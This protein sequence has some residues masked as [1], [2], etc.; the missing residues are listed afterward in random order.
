MKYILAYVAILSGLH[1]FAQSLSGTIRDAADGQLLQGASVHWLNTGIGTTSDA[2]GA[3][4]IAMPAHLPAQMVVSYIGYTSDTLTLNSNTTLVVKLRATV[5]LKETEV[6]ETREAT[7]FSTIDPLNKQSLGVKELQKSACCNLSESFETNATVDVSYTDAVSGSKQIKLLGLEGSYTQVL[8][9]LMPGIRGLST[10]SGYAH[11]P[12]T[13]VQNIDIT[14]GTGSVVNGYES[15]SGQINIDLLKPEKADRL[16]VNVYAG[17]A[18]RYE[19]NVHLGHRFNKQWSSILLTHASGMVNKNDYNGDGYLDAPLGSQFNVMNKWRYEKPG[20]LMAMFGVQALVDNRQGGQLLFRNQ[21]DNDSMRAYGIRMHTQH[22]EA[23]SKTAWGF[24]GQPYKGLALFATAR[25][26]AQD[27]TYGLKTYK[28]QEQTGTL[29]LMYQSIIG[30]SDHKI[31]IGSSYLIDRY[32]ESYRD[33]AFSRTESVPGIFGE[34]NYERPGKWS[35]LAGM[36]ADYHNLFGLMLNPRLHLKFN[37]RPLTVLR[38]SAGRGMHTA[39][40]FIENSAALASSRQV[41]VMEKL[42]QEVAWNYGTS[43]VHKFQLW[44]RNVTFTV[45]LYRTDFEHQVVAD[46]DANPQQLIFYN[47][48]GASYSNNFQSEVAYEPFKR[49]ELRLAYKWQ[50]VHTTYH[51]VLLE[52]PLVARNRVL[53]NLAYATRFNKWKFDFTAK[54]FDRS[55]LPNTS[56]NP[57]GLRFDSYSR[58]Y[59]VFNT[60]VTRAFKR[61]EIYA[62]VENIFN[63]VQ[64]NQLIDPGNPFGPYFD[65]SMVWGPVMGRVIYGGLRFT[66]K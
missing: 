53:L 11:L 59:T 18:G 40:V 43:L 55:R 64:Q 58:P 63:Y 22:I 38:F 9:E 35:V 56:S 26:Y 16:F 23:F 29:N 7:T 48:K 24:T 13:W 17:D 31:K 28:G 19:T 44:H 3:F 41:I 62:G 8:H 50:D 45:D 21:E 32:N 37:L 57:E 66:I 36:R 25:S 46:L 61:I 5:T 2:N 52:K 49:F 1:A 33:S 34:Y 12:G 15:I 39:N 65:A 14:K 10:V 4:T 42:Q 51:G 30:T 27:A 20:R 6:T 60:Q 54:W 47:L